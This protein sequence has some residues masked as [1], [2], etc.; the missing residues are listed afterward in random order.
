MPLSICFN[1]RYNAVL[2]GTT[3]HECRLCNCKKTKMSHNIRFLLIKDIKEKHIDNV[4]VN[5]LTLACAHIV[6][7]IPRI[8]VYCC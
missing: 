2:R 8:K 7:C 1:P 5:A 4:N 3:R 6:T